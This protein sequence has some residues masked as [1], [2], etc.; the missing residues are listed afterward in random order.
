MS[1]KI[2]RVQAAVGDGAP[3]A[4]ARLGHPAPGRSRYE[5]SS[6]GSARERQRL[7]ATRD[8]GLVGG[9][10]DSSRLQAA[11]NDSPPGFRRRCG[12]ESQTCMHVWGTRALRGARWA[13]NKRTAA[14]ERRRMEIA[15]HLFHPRQ[16]TAITWATRP[17]YPPA[18]GSPPGCS[19][20]TFRHVKSCSKCRTVSLL[21]GAWIPMTSTQSWR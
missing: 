1:R 7:S 4:H 13:G 10:Q 3:D 8:L 14:R 20:R 5:L 21:P 17:G 19:Y 12:M 11:R 16:G 15:V 18:G 6:R 2:A 9:N